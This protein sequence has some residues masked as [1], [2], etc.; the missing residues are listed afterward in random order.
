M[1]YGL[2]SRSFQL[3]G[4]MIQEPIGKKFV[5]D[6]R[7]KG[8]AEFLASL[9]AGQLG[10]LAMAAALLVV[11][12]VFLGTGVLYPVQVIAATALGPG[13]L[14]QPTVANIALGVMLHQFG[15]A[16]FWSI[17]F[18]LVVAPGRTPFTRAGVLLTG[19]AIGAISMVIDV[20]LLMPPVQHLLNGHNLWAEHVPQGWDWIAHLVY[21]AATGLAFIAI[22]DRMRMRT[23]QRTALTSEERPTLRI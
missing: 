10:G 19:I 6:A 15:P 11:F 5:L 3:G 4:H 17:L 20:Y 2:A 14:V 12:P 1:R 23:R 7:E 13:A 21:G 18:G 8:A 16:L 9:F 22:R